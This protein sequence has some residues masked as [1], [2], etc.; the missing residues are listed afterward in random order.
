MAAGVHIQEPVLDTLRREDEIEKLMDQGSNI[1]LVKIAVEGII[2]G[3]HRPIEP[4]DTLETDFEVK[5]NEVSTPTT[6]GEKFLN[7]PSAAEVYF[8][9]KN[10]LVPDACQVTENAGETATVHET[11]ASDVGE[12]NLGAQESALE[13][14]ATREV[15]DDESMHVHEAGLP[16]IKE[17]VKPE[18][19]KTCVTV[20][21]TEA[22][23]SVEEKNSTSTSQEIPGEN[24][25]Q[26]T[27]DGNQEA[28]EKVSTVV[29]N[30]EKEQ[31]SGIE[32]N[33]S[34][35]KTDEKLE[36][37]DE[38]PESTLVPEG[39]I[40]DEESMV[41]ESFETKNERE[42]VI[43]KS[44]EVTEKGVEYSPVA[45][46][47]AEDIKAAN[48]DHDTK[49]SA[50]EKEIPTE[51][52]LEVEVDKSENETPEEQVEDVSTLSSMTGEDDSL[53]KDE[54][55]SEKE[56]EKPCF[57]DDETNPAD[58][59]TAEDEELSRSDLFEDKEDTES[60]VPVEAQ[61]IEK[62]VESLSAAPDYNKAC[63]LLANDTEDTKAST[64]DHD[65]E[66][67][68]LQNQTKT[69]NP[70]QIVPDVT[71]PCGVVDTKKE[72]LELQDVS[73]TES[74]DDLEEN[75]TIEED[76]SEKP[77]L[78]EEP[79][80]DVGGDES[81][82]T[83]QEKNEGEDQGRA[84]LFENP[85]SGES[86][87]L[88]ED[89]TKLKHVESPQVDAEDSKTHVLDQGAETTGLILATEEVSSDGEP[90][91]K[92]EVK[93]EDDKKVDQLFDIEKNP[94]SDVELEAAVETPIES[95]QETL[96]PT[97]PQGFDKAEEKTVNRI[98]M[99][100]E[101]PNVQHDVSAIV[102]NDD[103]EETSV[104]GEDDSQMK[105]EENLGEE[106]KTDASDDES[107]KKLE[108]K[109]EGEEQMRAESLEEKEET[110][111]TLLKEEET[112]AQPLDSPQVDVEDIKFYVPDEG[113]ETTGLIEEY[114]GVAKDHEPEVERNEDEDQTKV[115]LCDTENITDIA[116]LLESA[117]MEKSLEYSKE[118]LP[119]LIPQCF[120]DENIE[121]NAT[122]TFPKENIEDDSLL[123]GSQ[124]QCKECPEE[125]SEITSMIEVSTKNNGAN[126]VNVHEDSSEHENIRKHDFGDSK[127]TSQE[128][129]AQNETPANSS[130]IV[131]E[132]IIAS[133]SCQEA[134]TTSSEEVRT[135]NEEEAV[136][137]QI[138][139]VSTTVPNDGSGENSV[140]GK[141]DLPSVTEASTTDSSGDDS[142]N[143]CENKVEGEEQTGA[144]LFEGKKDMESKLLKEE[145]TMVRPVEFPQ[146]DTEDI[147]T[148]ISD[149]GSETTGIVEASQGDVDN[150]VSQVKN[151]D[152]TEDND[153][154]EDGL[155][156]NE[157][158]PE[159]GELLEAAQTN[160]PIEF[161]Q[162]TLPST[163]PLRFL[164]DNT[165][166]KRVDALQKDED[167][168]NV[169]ATVPKEKIE[170]NSFIQ[171]DGSQIQH[172]ENLEKEHEIP[173]VIEASTKHA[174]DDE[175]IV[176]EDNIEHED[177]RKVK[178]ESEKDTEIHLQ[179]DDAKT[180]IK[181][182]EGAAEDI[183]ASDSY[184]GIETT[185]SQEEQTLNENEIM[186]ED[187]EVERLDAGDTKKETPKALDVSTFVLKDD[188]EGNS[189]IGV[190]NSE[191]KNEDNLGKEC[192]NP[193]SI[194]ASR[195]DVS[196]D[197][198]TKTCEDKIEGE[199]QTRD[200]DTECTLLKEVERAAQPFESPLVDVKGIKTYVSD[201][202]TETKGLVEVFEEVHNDNQPDDRCTTITEDGDQREN[203]FC[204]IEKIPDSTLLLEVAETE[205]LFE[206]LKDAN[207]T[208]VPRGFL[209]DNTEEKIIYATAKDEESHEIQK[210]TTIV[211]NENIEDDSLIQV[212]GSQP[213]IEALT[214]NVTDDNSI[215]VHGDSSD[216]EDP[217]KD[218][219]VETKEDTT[220]TLQKE[221]A[222]VETPVKS[223]QIAVEDYIESD[224]CQETETMSF[225]GERTL[226]EEEIDV[227]TIVL[228]DDTETNSVTGENDLQQSVVEASTLD[229]SGDASTNKCEDTV[230]GE[231][232]TGAELFVDKKDT[233]S[234]LLKEE[235]ILVKKLVESSNVDT[236]KVRASVSDEGAEITGVE[237]AFEEDADDD[238]ESAVEYEVTTEDNDQKQ[239]KLCV[240]AKNPESGV[241][242]EAAQVEKPIESLQETLPSTV[243][244]KTENV[245]KADSNEKI[246][247]NSLNQADGSQIQ[248]EDYLKEGIELPS[249]IEVLTKHADDGDELRSTHDDNIEHKD[250]TKFELLENKKD[251]E[252]H[253]QKDE[254][255]E[256]PANSLQVAGEDVI[257]TDSHHETEA[258][259][260][261]DTLLNENEIFCEQTEVERLDT[262]DLDKEIPE[263]QNFATVLSSENMKES[264]LVLE[265]GS[266]LKHDEHFEKE[267]KAPP[268]SE[269]LI[270]EA[271]Y[272]VPEINHQDK[273]ED[274]KLEKD[275]EDEHL[276]KDIM[277]ENDTHAEIGFIKEEE[278]V[279]EL[280]EPEKK[281]FDKIKALAYEGT[282][283]TSSIQERDLTEVSQESV[284]DPSEDKIL[285]KPQEI[286]DFRPDGSQMKHE[287]LYEKE[288]KML[289]TAETSF[290]YSSSNE[291]VT[292]DVESIENDNLNKVDKFEDEKHIINDQMPVE[293][294]Q[295]SSRRDMEEVK[296]FVSLE[297]VET[298][299]IKEQSLTEMSPEIMGDKLEEKILDK[300]GTTWEFPNFV[301]DENG[302]D[303]SL[304]L[305]DEQQIIHKELLE[306]ESEP[307][308]LSET[309]LQKSNSNQDNIEDEL[310]NRVDKFESEKHA[311]ISLIKEEAP[312]EKLNESSLKKELEEIKEFDLS[313]HTESSSTGD[314]NLSAIRQENV[315]LF[316]SPHEMDLM[317]V[318]QLPQD[319]T[320][321]ALQIK[322]EELLERESETPPLLL[323]HSSDGNLAVT[324]TGKIEDEVLEKA[325]KCEC[326]ESGEAAFLNEEALAE[327]LTGSPKAL[328]GIKES[329]TGDRT[330]ITNSTEAQNLNIIS[331]E[332]VDDQVVEKVF[333][334][335]G[336]ASDFTTIIPDT[337]TE[338]NLLVEVDASQM[339]HEEHLEKESETPSLLSLTTSTE[340][341][342]IAHEDKIMEHAEIILSNEEALED[343]S[344]EE[345]ESIK[346]SVL[347]E[348]TE[349]SPIEQERLIAKSHEIVGDQAEETII[350]RA[351]NAPDL[352][353]I[354]SDKNAEEN[355][356]IHL[357][358]SQ[359]KHDDPLE[360]ESDAPSMSML[361][362]T[363]EESILQGHI[364]DEQDLGEV[365]FEPEK[366]AEATLLKESAPAENVTESAK[367]EPEDTK[368]LQSFEDKEISSI[369]ERSQKPNQQEIVVDQT[370]EN[371]LDSATTAQ[372]F[373]QTVSH[374]NAE[375]NS[376]IQ[377]DES[378][379]KHETV[380][381]Q[382]QENVLD[383]AP[384]DQARNFCNLNFTPAIS[385]DD[386]EEKS[387]IQVDE[388]EMKHDE[389]EKESETP[390][391]LIVDTS[392][393]KSR[394][395]YEDVTEDDNLK[396]FNDFEREK[397]EEVTSTEEETQVTKVNQSSKE[398]LEDIEALGSGED[399][400]TTSFEETWSL[401]ENPRETLSYQQEEKVLDIA[402]EA[403][404]FIEVVSNENVERDSMIQKDGSPMGLEELSEKEGETP[405]LSAALIT[406]STSEDSIVI[407]ENK[408][409]NEGTTEVDIFEYEK[410][411]DGKILDAAPEAPESI[412]IVLDVNNEE[413]SSNQVNK[414]QTKH[415]ELLKNEAS[416]DTSR[417]DSITI[418]DDIV[419]DEN[420]EKGDKLECEK[421]TELPLTKEEEPVQSLNN[422][423]EDIAIGSCL[424]T[425]TASSMED[426]SLQAN[427]PEV[428]GD[429][430]ED[431]IIDTTPEPQNFTALVSEENNKENLSLDVDESQ[432]KHEE[433]LENKSEK[434]S[435]PI[436]KTSKE[437]SSFISDS[438]TENEDVKRGEEPEQLDDPIEERSL[439]ENPQGN[440]TDDKVLDVV[441][442]ALELK[443]IESDE[444]I[445][446]NSIVL[447][448]G[449][450]TK[451]EERPEKES[452]IPSFAET[453]ILNA[454]NVEPTLFLDEKIEDEDQAKVNKS[455]CEKHA[456][457]TEL[458]D[459]APIVPDDNNDDNPSIQVEGSQMKHGELLQKEGKVP[460]LLETSLLNTH[461]EELE[462]IHN[463]VIEDDAL[464]NVDEFESQKC[465]EVNKLK[466]EAQVED[467]IAYKD[468][469]AYVSHQDID[470]SDL[471]EQILTPNP[472]DISEEN[473]IDTEDTE[474][475]ITENLPVSD[476]KESLI[477]IDESET[478]HEE[479]LEKEP[480]LAKTSTVEANEKS[481][482]IHEDMIVEESGKIIENALLNEGSPAYESVE[483]LQVDSEDIKTFV[484]CQKTD[485]ACSNLNADPQEN[486]GDQADEKTNSA[487]T[488]QTNLR[489]LNFA[490]LVSNENEVLSSMTPQDGLVIE[491]EE[492]SMM[493]A[494]EEPINIHGDTIEG[495]D[496]KNFDTSKCLQQTE[497]TLSKE[498][499]HED[500]PLDSL[501]VTSEPIKASVSCQDRDPTSSS[502]E[503]I[504]T[505]TPRIVGDEVEDKV[506]DTAKTWGETSEI[507]GSTLVFQED[508]TNR[509]GDDIINSVKVKDEETLHRD[510][511]SDEI[512]SSDKVQA[513]EERKEIISETKIDE[514][515]DKDDTWI[516][517][518][519][520]EI[521]KTYIEVKETDLS[522]HAED[523]SEIPQ[524]D[525]GE[526]IPKGNENS[527]AKN[528]FLEDGCS[529]G[530]TKSTAPIGNADVEH[531][532]KDIKE[533]KVITETGAASG[534][535]PITGVQYGSEKNESE[536]SRSK[537]TETSLAPEGR[538]Y[539]GQHSKLHESPSPPLSHVKDSEWE[540][541]R[542]R[543]TENLQR[544][545]DSK[546]LDEG[547]A[548]IS[549][550]RNL[551]RVNSNENIE[552]EVTAGEK[553]ASAIQ[554]DP[555]SEFVV[556]EIQEQPGK[557]VEAFPEEK[558][559]KSKQ[560]ELKYDDS[561]YFKINSSTMETDKVVPSDILCCSSSDA[562]QKA[563]GQEAQ[564]AL[565]EKERKPGKGKAIEVVPEEKGI[566]TEEDEI[567]EHGSC[568]VALGKVTTI[569][570][571]QCSTTDAGLRA[572]DEE[573]PEQHG[574]DE[575]SLK[576]VEEGPASATDK[577]TVLKV[578]QID[579]ANFD[580][581]VG[582][583]NIPV[584][585]HGDPSESSQTEGEQKTSEPEKGVNCGSE[586]TTKPM[587][588]SESTEMDKSSLL[589]LLQEPM[590]QV[591][592][593]LDHLIDKKQPTFQEEELQAEK[594][595]EVEH[596][597][598]KTGEDKDGGESLVVVDRADKEVKVAH[599]KS[600]GILSGVGS[601]VKHSI[602]K[603]KKA[604][605]GKSSHPKSASPKYTEKI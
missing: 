549:N 229:A 526:D 465:S 311:D 271:N 343:S 578:D 399:S 38:K 424:D 346:A 474:E 162:E 312:Q 541:V 240:N 417:E 87:S 123:D 198:S 209:D 196:V 100:K 382:T 448:A 476:V 192:E 252:I 434:P 491:H 326:M 344:K 553:E 338:R 556:K 220:T 319:S 213:I 377:V 78:R 55:H 492:I 264:S 546:D 545:D 305:V 57:A 29:S 135:S 272:E 581:S 499:A 1:T 13:V 590:K 14:E 166:V 436:L 177:Q 244:D 174:N 210:V 519:E 603:V 481:T 113:K 184:Q 469:K 324:H 473:S 559:I 328:E 414:S 532:D 257:P 235:E 363:T 307:S 286:Q 500:E 161:L 103:H 266:E 96:P 32:A 176:R 478:K 579:N 53:T 291:T 31:N 331:R 568:I 124:I 456:E 200:E 149:E 223:L 185:E 429:R 542:K 102:L 574:L 334:V 332:T 71:E 186:H 355:S 129:E 83:H 99:E 376:L 600:H 412:I 502:E 431:N 222:Q 348:D 97:V 95:L 279:K 212:D 215:N 276:D 466:E 398:D 70:Q 497:N 468:I 400:E 557:I 59:A 253:L 463:D 47:E 387:L 80:R 358:G 132:D 274:E 395:I 352:T 419:E 589:G 530:S 152:K 439:T 233:E 182:L 143:K 458:P 51:N 408:I 537:E 243:P 119:T 539:Q 428:M 19:T 45:A 118:A 516:K 571:L 201:Q 380:S 68:A 505:T 199:E 218:E 441:P 575:A 490:K 126:L 475:K 204:G 37:E 7:S 381:D 453:P 259:S 158:N 485:T 169:T 170:E 248:H 173:S 3:S 577:L 504:S 21:D 385:R 90:A 388:V 109:I 501:Q 415:K 146:V 513:K 544:G 587:K 122:T 238:D 258:T 534:A 599:K 171:M 179:E 156:V 228:N 384:M 340:E 148:Y 552:V 392:N 140:T 292:V 290:L 562:G 563:V 247:G 333:D 110:E 61:I 16:E 304:K 54:T 163:V 151:D 558:G 131:A 413:E 409:E 289:S 242:L 518:P 24:M 284:S 396:K 394:I 277:F 451:H 594:K 63:D 426:R 554:Q 421:Q 386:T 524:D 445:E 372:D 92:Y 49:T 270:M 159:R 411:V 232:H 450:Q 349:T 160:K 164:D 239:D 591:S 236:E 540:M 275:I 183:I 595:S 449:S 588:T 127:I 407:H 263:S 523:T 308:P 93:T 138:E 189:A 226:N 452:E 470:T 375:E 345:N 82:Y 522:S 230:E 435:L 203:E 260:P 320:T 181:S 44:E 69:E 580:S 471:E 117:H 379:V 216:H 337:D 193:P 39:Q 301:S 88:V 393:D 255:P 367:D 168:Q 41:N 249:D 136:R 195:T 300:V 111:S 457:I 327:K 115:E 314:R 261:A 10:N 443:T 262:A 564:I 11:D 410:P 422:P 597:E 447:E 356:S 592:E 91:V 56:T 479:I 30:K 175:L 293:Q 487:G 548:V 425:G 287:E 155:S 79:T 330:E 101:I 86:M 440:L 5:G 112:A 303:I 205:K 543:G 573:T 296:T 268:L 190:D 520:D 511:E 521:D 104:T 89:K 145:E 406:N 531:I 536:D 369:E 416:P 246:Q 42:T 52:P 403:H 389:L 241:L 602:S 295:E 596:I 165:E 405:S 214:R 294:P 370:Q 585:H 357:D 551:P 467:S 22:T 517:L 208:S 120:P 43:Q 15:G 188:Y 598:E 105:D 114:E 178:F 459:L 106:I 325:D 528:E 494:N 256:T 455:E 529:N 569:K 364:T 423:L 390:S 9:E 341:P 76:E 347:C 20:D 98:L 280:H 225:Q 4:P 26:I 144:E 354:A 488:R 302:E 81:T 507:S 72:A 60:T 464:K 362:T 433:L 378:Q 25:E 496:L 254:V 438:Q 217:R 62:H 125:E 221:E 285:A 329:F 533:E 297:R 6:E 368:V 373:K 561:D 172:E 498:E 321:N 273:I 437:E 503:Q 420:P 535:S 107:T 35:I 462:I 310:L 283:P 566:Y 137:E 583:N 134:E 515:A 350:D 34:Q 383:T 391:L 366:D 139:D 231:E 570:A 527:T 77:L 430:M 586:E 227:S 73:T 313:E 565:Q 446:E 234:T 128:E 461:K 480:Y 116:L 191:T 576:D 23:S 353:A 401:R 224:S 288:C 584:P 269:P 207:P 202:G 605:T 94:E 339:K 374:E 141:N 484:S 482:A 317:N 153:K 267:S 538:E 365:D 509:I 360:M 567:K 560:G 336:E 48:S 121:E 282:E 442:E 265:Y 219:L 17:D 85:N 251:A 309:S 351:Q 508:E 555:V 547:S 8:E 74:N 50:L 12:A 18:D 211:S 359:I 510:A 64:S 454:K 342:T 582:S 250:H 66:I 306:K 147:K 525:G 402:P 58:N 418:S 33:N 27:F 278:P 472:Q 444:N 486:A 512:C 245:A 432:I 371:I 427:P 495:E 460:S 361:G 298:S 322:H 397:H 67:S 604:I 84:E 514:E 593:G 197:E 237:E 404:N 65:V 46:S 36:K 572:T 601:K 142:A 299:S 40:K 130:D 318:L 483:S 506:T 154:N 150:D 206:S 75:S 108:D 167:V 477:Q 323:L 489:A 316:I 187:T 493:A 28:P 180:H 335:A 2:G 281:D 550:E 194:E 157:K 315:G 133:D